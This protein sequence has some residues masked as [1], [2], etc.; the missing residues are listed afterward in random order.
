ME[1]IKRWFERFRRS[2]DTDALGRVFD[3]TAP[4]L[5]QL[6]VHL[7]GDLAA[8]EDLVQ[9]TFVT[10]IERADKFDESRELE[11]WL[12]GILANHARDLNKAA[13]RTIDTASLVERIESTPLE[14]ALD[15]EWS[16]ALAQAL[17]RIPEPYRVVLILRLQHG[18]E[19]TEIAHALQRGPGAVR[20]QLH[21]RREM[22]RK[23]LPAG[24]LASAFF[25]AEPGRGLAHVKATV[26]AHAGVVKSG[27]GIAA[28]TGG[29]LVSSKVLISAAAIVIAL[30]ALFFA[31][32]RE[33]EAAPAIV[34]TSPVETRPLDASVAPREVV[35][36]VEPPTPAQREEAAP[37][38][39]ASDA[40][41]VK[42]HGRVFDSDTNAG[43]AG[44]EVRLYP[45]QTTRLSDVRRRWHDRLEIYKDGTVSACGWPT[46][47]AV[48]VGGK[49]ADTGVGT[50]FTNAARLDA[51]DLAVYAPP[52]PNANAIARAVSEANGEFEIRAPESL[53]FL[54]CNADGYAMRERAVDPAKLDKTNADEVS[55]Q[56]AMRAPKP[57]AGYVVDEN[58][59]R[60][61]RTV[62]LRFDGHVRKPPFAARDMRTGKTIGEPDKDPQMDS[63]VVETKPDGSFECELPAKMVYALSLEPDLDIVKQGHL[64]DG[65]TTFVHDVWPEP[66]HVD[67]PL[68]IVLQ[69]VTS[70]TVRDRESRQPIEDIHILCTRDSNSRLLRYG[71]FFAP[72]GRMRLS[73]HGAVDSAMYPL[74][75]ELASCQCTVWANGYL[76]ATKKLHDL[77]RP[78]VI[79]F[80]L[81]R[82]EPPSVAGR[83][84]DGDHA[85]SRARVQLVGPVRDAWFPPVGEGG[86]PI[87]MVETDVNG[88]FRI[89]AP[90]GRYVLGVIASESVDYRII[91]L[92]SASP[93]DIDFSIDTAIVA[94]VHESTGA[95]CTN[96]EVVLRGDDGR[97]VKMNTDA[98]GVACF[99]RLTPGGY[100]VQTMIAAVRVGTKPD[101][102][103]RVD[104]HGG[105]RASAQFTLGEQSPRYAHLVVESL[106]SFEG[107]KASGKRTASE[108]WIDVESSGRIPIDI[109]GLAY[110]RLRTSDERE[111][112]ALVPND[113]P[114]GY[115]V[116]IALD[117]RGYE[118]VVTWQATHRPIDGVRVIARPWNAPKDTGLVATAIADANGHFT[119]T[120]LADDDY[121]IRFEDSPRSGALESIYVR[122][123]S[124]PATPVAQLVLEL[125]RNARSF[126]GRGEACFDG[127]APISLAGVI[128]KRSGALPSLNGFLGSMIQRPGYTLTLYTSF[129]VAQDGSFEVRV[130]P[131]PKYVASLRLAENG[132]GYSEIEWNAAGTS[133]REVHD[134]EIP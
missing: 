12:A 63:W 84:H 111:W 47:D 46:I 13:R 25:I 91:E 81:E 19:P 52:A 59:K 89:S 94:D 62:R 118:G 3:A 32:S 49:R 112:T 95:P 104:L 127:F 20:V 66:G 98:K 48:P 128:R 2:G 122:P 23:E 68:V 55:I 18:M 93:V 79:E 9:A 34:S 53:G 4:R 24:I 69:S 14:Q 82:G 107:W 67:E 75:D 119:L 29:L 109:R 130:P 1:D 124:R 41:L 40:K 54:V 108:T 80:E 61:E 87:E 17:D 22:L 100:S 110:L 26:V 76:P 38:T 88:A 134:I 33:H 37:A 99:S 71:R 86:V 42:L 21:R 65:G 78:G 121:S 120:G 8:A 97:R 51:Q 57:L 106:H 45:P 39:A 132:E 6:A 27:V 83:V 102:E 43:I 56:I 31:R 7:V 11:A 36:P 92:P 28:I 116:R 126:S 90:A 115:E 101:R 10:A 15:A 114:D 133:D 129:S 70:L 5:L 16:A 85:L 58:L 123:D 35:A 131:A 64:H 73:D 44:A 60:I 125:P 77:T 50:N 105:E 96:H 113:A 30:L 74:E 72:S 103:T 117:G